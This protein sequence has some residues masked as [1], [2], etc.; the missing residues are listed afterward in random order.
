MAFHKTILLLFL[1]ALMSNCVNNRKLLTDEVFLKD[2][3]SYTG[4]IIKCDSTKIKLKQ[5]DESTLIIPWLKVDSIGGKKLKTFWFGANFGYYKSPYFSV[6]RNEA[7]TA[8]TAGFQLKAGT[9]RR[10]NKLYYFHITSIPAKP[11]HVTKYGLGFQKYLRGT[12]YLTLN[13]FFA[14]SE[15]NFMNAKFNNGPQITLEPYAGFERKISEQLRLHVK[16]ELQFNIANKNN[17]SGVSLTVGAHFLKRNFKKYYN[18]LN[19]E[20]RIP[21]K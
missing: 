16:L 19:R 20:R 13:S 6:F 9:A 7:L 15:I 5:L 10:G 14:G 8:E 2:G 12:T 3:N 18:T 4:T 1:I 21:L 17:K 11:Y